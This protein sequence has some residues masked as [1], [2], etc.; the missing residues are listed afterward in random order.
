MSSEGWKYSPSTNNP[1]NLTPGQVATWSQLGIT[2]NANMSMSFTI[3]VQNINSNWRS[4]FHVTNYNANCCNVGDRV[5]AL[6]ITAD[7]LTLYI[8]NSTAS[9][10]NYCFSTN[11]SLSLNTD[12]NVLITWSGQTVNIYL[13]DVLDI[14]FN[15]NEALTAA[16]G[17]AN[18]YICDPWY[19]TGGFTIENFT[20]S[21]GDTDSSLSSEQWEY[22]PST[23]SPVSLTPTQVA[24]WSELGITTNTNMSI[25]FI[26]N[27]Q[28]I[29]SN[30]RSILHITNDNT[31]CCDIGSR[32]PAFWITA[33]ALTL[34]IANSTSSNGNDYFYTNSS[35]SLNTNTTILITWVGQTVT[36]YFNG[37]FDSTFTHSDPLTAPN[38]DANVYICD[39]WYSTGGFTIE[40]FIIKGIAATPALSTN[41]FSTEYFY[42][43]IE[44]EDKINNLIYKDS[45]KVIMIL[46]IIIF[47]IYIIY[48][49]TNKKK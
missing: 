17:N 28:N 34:C 48:C 4:I 42:N 38:G 8:C 29:N 41:N 20:V 16:N 37:N 36:V 40:N 46:T 3:N 14:T 19:S 44:E 45:A 9:N 49:I 22:G 23:N 12:T 2:S 32:I 18:V 6:W 27:V 43:Q 47:I 10:G 24:T 7:A 35:I 5:P 13:N 11:S 1:V 31:D 21:N 26:I 15:Y 25:S 30:W 33:G 39:P